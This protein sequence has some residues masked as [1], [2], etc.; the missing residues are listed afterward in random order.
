MRQQTE[1]RAE[2]R[3]VVAL[4]KDYYDGP[5]DQIY[6][7]IWG[8]NLHIGYFE[9]DGESL[10]D[11]MKR[12]N[13]RMAEGVALAAAD[14]VLDVGSGYGALARFLARQYGCEV[15]ASNISERE[16]EWGRE[17]TADQGLED[18]VRF[19]WADFHALPFDG[20]AFDYYWSQEAFLH[21]ADKATVLTEAQ[22]VLKPG[23]AIVFTDLLVR[24]GTPAADRER[25]YERVKSPDMWDTGAYL[26]ALERSGFAIEAHEDW[27]EHVAPTYAWVREQLELRRDWFEDRI[28]RDAVDRTSAALQFWVDAAGDGRIGWEYFVARTH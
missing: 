12:S 19:E 6:R 4:T 16:L 23:G 10:H 20:D 18:K 3:D 15:V 25:I 5:A 26:G 22:R 11:A 8:E 27:S 28:G 14:T 21:A 2:V 1:A 17:L 9:R 13:E 7:H 24:D